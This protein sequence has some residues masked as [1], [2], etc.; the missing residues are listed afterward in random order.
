MIKLIQKRDIERLI[1]E[2]IRLNKG[3]HRICLHDN[4]SDM[5][6]SMV[7]CMMPK[8][9]SGF[10]YH[11]ENDAI[12]TYSSLINS[13]EIEI[14]EQSSKN[15]KTIKLDEISRIISIKD[16]TPRN[17]KNITDEPTIYLEH[18]LGPYIID[19]IYWEDKAGK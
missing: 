10:H 3:W 6:H 13:L 2:T 14:K 19:N 1:E 12:I 17:V 5:M 7:M 18:R 4:P 9:E 11:K 16:K 8:A 15:F